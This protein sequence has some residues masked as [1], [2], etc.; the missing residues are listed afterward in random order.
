M[1]VEIAKTLPRGTGRLTIAFLGETSDPAA[2]VNVSVR[3]HLREACRTA[4]FRGREK[5]VAGTRTESGSWTLVGLGHLPLPQGKLRRV[6]RQSI[7]AALRGGRRDLTLVFDVGIP[8][9]TLRMLVR[10]VS[11]A[12][13]FFDRYK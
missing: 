8:D 10:E 3:Q 12:D 5:E 9:A 6:V 4:G 11:Q 13:Y 2:S 7:R 1:R